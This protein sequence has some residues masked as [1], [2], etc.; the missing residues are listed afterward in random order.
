M[1]ATHL[2]QEVS[3]LRRLPTLTARPERPACYHQQK[4]QQCPSTLS[5]SKKRK[6]TYSSRSST[7]DNV[8]VAEKED[9]TW[10]GSDEFTELGDRSESRH[11][12]IMPICEPF[13]IG[14]WAISEAFP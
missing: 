7:L 4:G 9:F 14:S 10:K 8:A 12:Y 11:S 13:G 3:S 5:E 2:G 1:H 6:M